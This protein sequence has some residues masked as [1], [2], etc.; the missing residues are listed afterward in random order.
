MDWTIRPGSRGGED[1]GK[2]GE[3]VLKTGPLSGGG[4]SGEGRGDGKDGWGADAEGDACGEE[5]SRG[6]AFILNDGDGEDDGGERHAGAGEGFT[7]QG[8][9]AGAEDPAVSQ[10]ASEDR[11]GADQE[12]SERAEEGQLVVGDVALFFEVGGEPGDQEVQAIVG[13]ELSKGSGPGVEMAEDLADGRDGGRILT[14]FEILAAGHP[15]EPG[16]EPGETGG[17]ENKQEGAPAVVEDEE[18]AEQGPDGGTG[19]GGCVDQRVGKAAAALGKVVDE[20][21][22]VRGVGNG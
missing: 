17:A 4:G 22:G 11:D 10:P 14:G 8:G 1:A 7:D 2:V 18:T 20:D 3:A 6:G 21:A 12:E 9:A 15:L 16:E 5:Q 19:L 13:A